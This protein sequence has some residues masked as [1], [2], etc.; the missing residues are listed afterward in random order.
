MKVSNDC[1]SLIKQF[2]GCRLTAYKCPA[3]V[4]TIG[5]GHTVGVKEGLVCNP[6]IRQYRWSELPIQVHRLQTIKILLCNFVITFPKGFSSS[7]DLLFNHA[8][9]SDDLS[10][11]AGNPFGSKVSVS[12]FIFFAGDTMIFIRLIPQAFSL[13]PLL[14]LPYHLLLQ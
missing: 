7:F 12:I 9:I 11:K 14:P 4:W 8:S 10:R 3:G 6:F 5:Y 2:E 1:I 13:D